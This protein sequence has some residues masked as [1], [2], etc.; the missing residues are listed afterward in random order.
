MMIAAGHGGMLRVCGNLITDRTEW[1][2]IFREVVSY[3]L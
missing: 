2:F 1:N 3:V